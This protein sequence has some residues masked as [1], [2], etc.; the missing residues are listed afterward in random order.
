MTP[1]LR[2][3]SLIAALLLGLLLLDRFADGETSLVAP[4]AATVPTV[5]ET[6]VATAL[7]EALRQF[8]LFQPTRQ[9]TA[10]PQ[11]ASLPELALA[12]AE[13]PHPVFAPAL[14]G[15]VT[16]PAPGGALITTADEA[17]VYLRPGQTQG[18]WTLQRV[19]RD[20]AL[21]TTPEGEIT[22]LLPAA[23]ELA[24]P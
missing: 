24:V 17:A 7:P 15:V 3:L 14:L 21:F 12:V 1:N 13:E 18:G 22:L 20:R 11:P 6:L 4:L 19:D 16:E 2:L 23:Q 5:T 10:T 9:V 8:P